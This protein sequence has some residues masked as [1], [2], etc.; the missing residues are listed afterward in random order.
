VDGVFACG[1]VLHVHDLVDWVTEEAETCGANAAAYLEGTYR[2]RQRRVVAGANVRYVIPGRY[3]PEG[4]NRLYL[5]P[6]VVKNRAE[7]VVRLDGE[8]IKRK[9]LAH[10]QPSEMV[11][12]TLEPQAPAAAPGREQGLLEVA[13]Q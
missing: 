13:I 6:L 7:L 5:R 12:F 10:V 11:S 8:P 2:R 1:N 9:R 3:F 4:A